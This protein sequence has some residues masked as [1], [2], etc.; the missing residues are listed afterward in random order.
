LQ[1][2]L[3]ELKQQLT[4]I[5]ARRQIQEMEL[6]T[7]DN[8]ALKNRLET[9]FNKLVNDQTQKEREVWQSTT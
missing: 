8:A 3:N 9:V 4:E 2:Q 7:T 6:G 1:S 5:S